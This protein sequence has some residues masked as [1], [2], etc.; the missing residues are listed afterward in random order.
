MFCVPAVRLHYA[1]TSWGHHR[2]D[3]HPH[4]HI[5]RQSGCSST[6][7]MFSYFTNIKTNVSATPGEL[8]VESWVRNQ[9]W[10]VFLLRFIELCSKINMLAHFKENNLSQQGVFHFQEEVNLIGG[11]ST[12]RSM[13]SHPVFGCFQF[14][15]VWDIPGYAGYEFLKTG[16]SFTPLQWLNGFSDDND[17]S[18]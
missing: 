9:I 7:T 17:E 3:S 18:P 11:I 2:I 4:T 6:S 16:G 10:L 8:L 14:P 15:E 13:Q 5:L 1:H 12:P